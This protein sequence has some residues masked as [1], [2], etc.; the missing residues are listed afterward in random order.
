MSLLPA[1]RP[2]CPQ[3]GGQ[4]RLLYAGYG[5]VQ[6]LFELVPK[7]TVEKL[8]ELPEWQGPWP[9]RSFDATYKC[10]ECGEKHTVDLPV[11]DDDA[12]D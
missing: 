3:C 4:T 9:K 2:Q 6:P 7:E 11:P 12:S 8:M 1:V 5:Y 10:E